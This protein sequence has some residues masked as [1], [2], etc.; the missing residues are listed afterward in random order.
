MYMPM[1]GREKGNSTKAQ[2][3]GSDFFAFTGFSGFSGNVSHYF[4]SKLGEDVY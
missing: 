4:F 1:K 2:L 3:S